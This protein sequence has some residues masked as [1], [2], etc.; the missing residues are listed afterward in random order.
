MSTLNSKRKWVVSVFTLAVLVTAWAWTGPVIPQLGKS[1]AFAAKKGTPKE[2]KA[3]S[4]VGITEDETIQITLSALFMKRPLKGRVAF[5]KLDGEVLS[6]VTFVVEPPNWIIV[7][8]SGDGLVPDG[9]DRV[10][11]ITLLEFEEK[12]DPNLLA[13]L[14][15]YNT[16]DGANGKVKFINPPVAIVIKEEGTK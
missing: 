4:P 14:E 3:I 15:W 2:R 12:P 8:Q 6:E 7:S 13:S 16:Q 5:L 10:Q 1:P 11:V 9:F